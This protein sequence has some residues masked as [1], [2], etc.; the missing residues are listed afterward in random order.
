M[1]PFCPVFRKHV[2]CLLLYVN[3]N[4]VS[5]GDR[6]PENT[7]VKIAFPI[8]EVCTLQWAEAG[9]CEKEGSRSREVWGEWRALHLLTHHRVQGIG[10]SSTADSCNQIR[11]RSKVKKG[12]WAIRRISSSKMLPRTLK[13]LKCSQ[14][15][16]NTTAVHIW[17]SRLQSLF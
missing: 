10:P 12:S 7:T 6:F 3:M 11:P 9:G 13:F 14:A 2:L 17:A 16:Q 8:S 4:L 5:L 1:L 15:N